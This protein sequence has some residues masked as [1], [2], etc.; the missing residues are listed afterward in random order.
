MLL[1]EL[2]AARSLVLPENLLSSS[3]TKCAPTMPFT[4]VLFAKKS[5]LSS[6]MS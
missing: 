6:G 1:K 2:G 5:L 3:L 4:A